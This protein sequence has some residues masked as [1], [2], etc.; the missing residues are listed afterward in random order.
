[1]ELIYK[2]TAWQAIP[3]LNLILRLY[4][5]GLS[6]MVYDSRE[7]KVKDA[8]DDW[9]IQALLDDETRWQNLVSLLGM[10]DQTDLGNQTDLSLVGGHK[11]YLSKTNDSCS[12]I[13]MKNWWLQYVDALKFLCLPLA[14]LIT[15]VKRKIVLGT[16][17]S[18]ASA[19]LSTIHDA[20]LQFCDGCLFLQ[21]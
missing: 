15:S 12:G 9:K 7:S 8:T 21:R 1:M 3:Q 19:H 2:L 5:S 6:I 16:E 13:N 14:T 20:F 17:M 10:V 18:C 11:S 4:S